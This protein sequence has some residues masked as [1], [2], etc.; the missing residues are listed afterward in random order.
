MLTINEAASK[1][2]FWGKKIDFPRRSIFV[3]DCYEAMYELVV[4]ELGMRNPGERS[5]PAT[6]GMIITGTPGIGKS[7]FSVYF[8][9]RLVN[10]ERIQGVLFSDV[11]DTAHL[12][13][14]ENGRLLASDGAIHALNIHIPDGHNYIRLVDLA[15]REEPTWLHDGPIIVF[16]SP[17][18]RRFKELS[19]KNETLVLYMPI[20]TLDEMEDLRANCYPGVTQKRTFA[21]FSVYGGVPRFVL[22]KPKT[23]TASSVPS[24]GDLTYG[25]AMEF[26][27]ENTVEDDLYPMQM[28]LARV[29]TIQKVVDAY[30]SSDVDDEVSHMLVHVM[31]APGNNSIG[32]Y[33]FAS[34]FVTRAVMDLHRMQQINNVKSFILLSDR[35]GGSAR[36]DCFEDICHM[37]IPKQGLDSAR[38]LS[39]GSQMTLRVPHFTHAHVFV[40]RLESFRD[41]AGRSDT[42]FQ[43]SIRSLEAIDSFAKVG[44]ELYMFQM[45]VRGSHPVKA[46]GLEKVIEEFGTGCT[47]FH[48]VF[49]VPAGA[50]RQFSE[51]KYLT[52]KMEEITVIP[53]SVRKVKQW[54]F[55]APLD[56]EF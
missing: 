35:K 29:Q 15:A 28:A 23:T 8:A 27:K 25:D 11:K 55:G 7:S 3:R 19:K 22:G 47:T 38:S 33:Q 53:A 42:Y 54:V 14:R 24:L 50:E 21:L 56:V 9:W 45:T 32:V 6:K 41:L 1:V 46:N 52:L 4:T 26:V 16:S 31:P 12:L 51:Q 34:K 48:L 39:G 13:V 36:G 5:S 40:P 2:F 30:G 18:K 44:Q 43:P 49:V 37:Y 17:D 20:F 10:D